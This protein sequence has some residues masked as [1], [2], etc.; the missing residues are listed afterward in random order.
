MAFARTHHPRRRALLVLLIL[1][2]V[3]GIFAVRNLGHWLIKQDALEHA[4]AIVLLSG[5][6]PYRAE[7]AA[8]IFN[9][10]YAPEVWIS[11]SAGPQKQLQE[12]GIHFVGEEDYDRDVLTHLGVPASHISIFPEEIVNT[13][14]EIAEVAKMMRAQGK[15]TVIIVTS[16]QHTRRVRALWNAIVGRDAKN[17]LKAIVR[18]APTDP[19]DADHWWRNSRD[20]LAVAREIL[21]LS[22]VWFGLPVRPRT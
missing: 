4:D 17:D 3:L 10:G 12:M 14:E 18:A 7:G 15:H 19:F 6:L 8:E 2:L 1:L 5:G 16:P 9:Q 11:L 20:S 21:G 13:E 22:N